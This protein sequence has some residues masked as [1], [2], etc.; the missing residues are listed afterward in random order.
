MPNQTLKQSHN[1]HP[2]NDMISTE[3]F[4]IYGEVG[5]KLEAPRMPSRDR[6]L[7]FGRVPLQ[8]NGRRFWRKGLQ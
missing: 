6:R 7:V 3:V 1:V 4:G 2:H 8:K 5:A